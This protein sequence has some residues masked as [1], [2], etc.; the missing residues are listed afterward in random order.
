MGHKDQIS[1]IGQ[2]SHIVQIGHL[3]Q[4][5]HINISDCY[6][7]MATDFRARE[8][9]HLTCMIQLTCMTYLTYQVSSLTLASKIANK[10]KCLPSIVREGSW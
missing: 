5:G 8:Q 6:A 9:G 10:D 3:G 2:I 4:T 1:H 7:E